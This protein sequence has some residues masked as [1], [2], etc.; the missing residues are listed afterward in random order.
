MVVE[1]DS[2]SL[3][4]SDILIDHNLLIFTKSSCSQFLNL[5]I[6]VHV[7]KLVKLIIQ[8]FKS[9]QFGRGFRSCFN[10]RS[11]LLFEIL[12]LSSS[13]NREGRYFSLRLCLS[14]SLVVIF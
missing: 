14:V 5:L 2:C 10:F 1:F 9:I 12:Y 8:E 11:F 3:F 7:V 4:V 6:I 13:A